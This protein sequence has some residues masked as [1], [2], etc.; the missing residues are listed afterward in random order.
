MTILNLARLLTV[1][2]R[3]RVG[4]ISRPQAEKGAFT[5]T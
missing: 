5:C 2:R 4:S 1:L 3:Q